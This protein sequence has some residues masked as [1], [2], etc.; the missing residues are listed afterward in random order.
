M[1]NQEIWNQ[2]KRDNPL[3]RLKKKVTISFIT[4]WKEYEVIKKETNLKRPKISYF[5]IT[6]ILMF[7]HD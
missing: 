2:Y 6:F 5:K 7:I 4:V 3:K 1:T